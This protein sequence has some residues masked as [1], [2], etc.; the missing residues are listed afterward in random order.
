L[1]PAQAWNRR[2][3]LLASGGGVVGR[4]QPH[5]SP[6]TPAGHHPHRPH[7]LHLR[8]PERRPPVQNRE[9]V[10][11]R[12]GPVARDLPPELAPPLASHRWDPCT[13]ATSS[14]PAGTFGYPK[15]PNHPA[16]PNPYQPRNPHPP[17]NNRSRSRSRRHHRPHHPITHQPPTT[18][19][20][21]PLTSVQRTAHRQ[22]EPPRVCWRPG[23]LA[24][25][26]TGVLR[27]W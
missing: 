1:L 15:T 7:Q 17:D 5:G 13:T 11:G 25:V 6:G 14:T 10:A 19:E 9:G 27:S 22:G 24:P 23:Y 3:G 8:G 18:P 26:G 12:P 20:P 4:R 2:A 16:T 21:W